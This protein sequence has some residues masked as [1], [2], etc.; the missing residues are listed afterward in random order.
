MEIYI[1]NELFEKIGYIDHA[2][3]TLW[4]PRYNDVGECEIYIQCDEYNLSLLQK[5][6]YIHRENE[7]MLC[8]IKQVQ[9]ETSIE[10]GDY[11]I[12]VGEDMLGILSDR[13]VKQEI[14]YS[15]TVFGFIKKL[16]EDNVIN[17]TETVR[18]INN[19]RF[20]SDNESEFTE[21][22]TAN[23]FKEDLLELIK[24]TCKTYNYGIKTKYHYD[25]KT[26]HV[27]L[28]KGENKATVE[29]DTYV[30]F[31]PTFS[32]IISSNYSEDDTN[33]KNVCYI[34]YKGEDE[35]THLLTLY[36]GGKEPSG[37]QRKEIYVDGSGA[38]RDITV[39]ELEAIYPTGLTTAANGTWYY[40]GTPV[41]KTNG[42]KVTVTDYTYL[43]II[44]KLGLETL[45]ERV[46]T[47]EFKGNVDVINTYEY[48]TDYNLGDIVKVINEYGIEAEARITEI[49]ES[50]DNDNGYAI[51]PKFEYIN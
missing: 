8:Q 19:I 21:T 41:A 38:S 30:E 33:Y 15:G 3:S 6:Y 14:T 48:K 45:A 27:R 24:K 42:D 11:I 18:K 16:I 32:N 7:D 49:V 10:N 5:G 43:I 26:L 28:Y 17:P 50:E 20:D 22:I 34:G 35:K 9:I 4:I 37:G 51:E 12:A 1:L 36:E 29:S 47:K 44:R 2:D 31:S 13:C 23:A 40:N 39:E 46:K 25:T